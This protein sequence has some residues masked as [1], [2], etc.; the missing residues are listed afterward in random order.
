MLTYL[1]G[2]AC[3]WLAV[4]ACV[5]LGLLVLASCVLRVRRRAAVAD[6][7]AAKIAFF[8][9]YCNDGGGG[10]RVLW[11]G[12]AEICRRNPKLKVAV[13]TGD[14]E[15]TP[16]EIRKHCL[17][18]FN[19]ELPE[20][21]FVYLRCRHWVEASRYPFLTLFGQSL[22]SVVLAFEALCRYSPPVFVDTTGC[23]PPRVMLPAA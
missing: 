18:R 4:V 17:D 11:C 23:P 2:S 7:K 14:V 16:D 13:Y 15:V 6:P 5:C 8:H 3:Y 9:P 19:I 12:I 22:G 20:I 10:E 21:D 1:L